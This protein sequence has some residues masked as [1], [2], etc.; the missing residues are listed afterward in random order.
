MIYPHDFYRQ[1]K[2]R[3]IIGLSPVTDCRFSHFAPKCVTALV[4]ILVA[5]STLAEARSPIAG[6]DRAFAKFVA[7]LWP[8]AE[9]KGVSRKTFDVAFKGVAF[10][11]RI[12]S[13]TNS[14]AEFVKP[15]WQYLASAVSPSRI[16]RGRAKAGKEQIWLIKARSEFGVDESIIMGIWGMETEFGA[17]E[18]SDNVIQSLATLA[19]VRYRGEYFRDE[20][21]SAL[22]ILERGDI[23]PRAMVGSWAGAMGQTQFMPSSFLDYAIDF[24]GAGKRD[25]WNDDADAIGSTANYL[26]KHGW[27]SGLPWGFEVMLPRDFKLMARDSS[28][29]ASFAEFAQRGVERVHGGALPGAGEARLLIPAGLDGPIFLVTSNFETI[30]SYNNSTSYALGVALLGDEIVRGES[31]RAGW[32]IHDL[33]LSPSQVRTLQTRLKKMGYVVGDIDGQVGDELRAAIRSYQER[34]GLPPDGYPTAKLLKRT[35]D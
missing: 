11:P 16:E 35:N 20:L 8:L 5:A 26:A 33:S 24:D 2:L 12:I 31:L 4:M 25:I 21:I 23:G 18:G 30:K 22:S 9:A 19:Y 3:F 28:F 27:T 13:L 29:P 7:D 1:R 14:Q 10:D 34:T 6:G 15:I 17:F 32:P